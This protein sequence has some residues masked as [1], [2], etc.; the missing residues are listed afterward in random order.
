MKAVLCCDSNSLSSP[1]IGFVVFASINVLLI[2]SCRPVTKSTVDKVLM[3]AIVVGV[4]Q[5]SLVA[6]D[7]LLQG[8]V[9][10]WQVESSEL[11]S[12]GLVRYL[13]DLSVAVFGLYWPIAAYKHLGSSP[14]RL[15]NAYFLYFMAVVLMGSIGLLLG[16]SSLIFYQAGLRW[17]MLLHASYGVFLF[18]RLS[19]STKYSL[20]SYLF[21]ALCLVDLI[22]V[23]IQ[24]RLSSEVFGVRLGEGRISGLFSNAATGAYFAVSLALIASFVRFKLRFEKMC[25][26]FLVLSIALASGT[27]FAIISV[28]I[29]YISSLLEVKDSDRGRNRNGFAF[30]ALVVSFGLIAAFFGYS[31]MINQIGRGDLLENQLNEGGRLAN[32]LN[33][34]DML[35]SATLTE[36]MFGRGLGVGTNTANTMLLAAGDNPELYRF[37]VLIDNSIVT[38]FFQ[39]GMMGSFIL[40]GGVALFFIMCAKKCAAEDRI[41]FRVGVGIFSLVLFTQN[42]FEQYFLMVAF[43]YYF[44]KIYWLPIMNKAI[45]SRSVPI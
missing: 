41:K 37:N 4:A 43:A 9:V 17:V 16:Y 40:W 27:R 18:I 34:L 30:K 10:L 1:P 14:R 22:A 15:V 45:S 39:F 42:I 3:L 21:F 8:K 2:G 6:I 26:Y 35:E 5:Y 7:F 19:P 32:I 20:G 28:F 38:A 25:L 36:V 12:G 31:A 44:G 13:K 33:V 23:V 11:Q 24:F 29:I